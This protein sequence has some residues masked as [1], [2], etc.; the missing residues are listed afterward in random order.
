MTATHEEK[1][2]VRAACLVGVLFCLALAIRVSGIAVESFW[3]DEAFTAW[4]SG[5]TASEI[6]ER[7]ARDIHPPAYY[8]G[9]HFWRE[10]TSH[11]DIALRAYSTSW[12]LLGIALLM[13]F[14][15]DLFG[16]RVA[17]LAGLFAAI[18]P[19]D[20]FFAQEARMY[21]QTT[22]LALATSF[23][24]WRWY[25]A[26]RNAD[27]KATWWRWAVVYSCA[28]T[29]LLLT[30]YVAATFL[31]GQ[32]IVALAFFAHRGDR[33]SV[34]G[35]GLSA[36]A[37]ALVFLPWLLYVLSFRDSIVRVEGLEWMPVPGILDYV[38]FIGREY[39]WGRAHKIHD[40][41]WIPTMALPVAILVVPAVRGAWASEHPQARARW[42]F[43]FA[44]LAAPLAVC[45]AVCLGY[46]VIYYRPR[47]VVLLLP[48]FLILLAWSCASFETRRLQSAAATSLALLMVF[49]SWIQQQ[50]PQKRAWRETAAAWPDVQAPAFYVVLP[51]FHQRSLSHYLDGRIRHTPQSVLEKLGPLPE[52]AHIW[53]ATWPEDLAENDAAYRAWLKGVGP[54]RNLLLPTYYSITRVEPTGGDVWPGFARD[55]FRAWYRPF[56]IAGE[57]SGFS[58]ATRF[59][60]LEFDGQG[61]VFRTA[62]GDARLRIEGVAA[63]E[64]IVLQVAGSQIEDTAFHLVRGP[65]A[66]RLFDG[67]PETPNLSS[68]DDGSHEIRITA[69]KGEGSLW[70]GWKDTSASQNA[71]ARIRVGWIGIQSVAGDTPALA[72]NR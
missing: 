19:L 56:D 6:L 40:A 51:D 23:A 16:T 48:Y 33:A 14:A 36:L 72:T 28:A 60:R 71:E 35:Y 10:L 12:S 65:S 4:A 49:G 5:G 18:N 53:V 26:A 8:L 34:V 11:S 20:V 70:L 59:S 55:R 57:L 27:G 22:T 25:E 63:G 15:R 21:A 1:D 47:Y 31:I 38:S 45:A 7:N 32:G 62:L 17:L 44:H 46:Q 43:V 39:F 69:P 58:D 61:Q 54:A 68:L 24:L 52:G 50:T 9:L 67:M 64:E 42:L 29:L 41:W 2:G 13:L 66:A 30:H 3:V 37:V